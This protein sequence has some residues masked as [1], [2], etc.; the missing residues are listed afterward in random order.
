MG[1]FI[2]VIGIIIPRVLMVAWWLSDPARWSSLF[3]SWLLPGLGFVFLPWTTLW[4][5]VFKPV[6]FDL[7]PTLILIF[8][9]LADLGTWGV[10]AFAGRKRTSFYRDA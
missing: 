6:G 4:Y 2:G 7:I 8:A 9:L 10:G 1:C 3:D 5:V